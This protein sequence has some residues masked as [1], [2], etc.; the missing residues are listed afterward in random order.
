MRIKV[1][2]AFKKDF[3]KLSKKDK[4]LIDE[5]ELLLSQLQLEERNYGY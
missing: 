3:K 1:T 5:Y 4:F 2:D